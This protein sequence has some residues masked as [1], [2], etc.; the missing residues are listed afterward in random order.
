[1][2]VCFRNKKT[3]N[4]DLPCGSSEGKITLE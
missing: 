1:M 4:Y 2:D 3:G